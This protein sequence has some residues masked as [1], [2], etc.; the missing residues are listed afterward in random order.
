MVRLHKHVQVPV[1]KLNTHGPFTIVMIY[2][3]GWVAHFWGSWLSW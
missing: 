2:L 1:V 3:A